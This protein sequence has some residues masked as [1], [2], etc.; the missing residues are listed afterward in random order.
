MQSVFIWYNV[1]MVNIAVCI[2][3]YNDCYSDNIVL[4]VLVSLF[5]LWCMSFL[6]VFL[7]LSFGFIELNGVWTV[8]SISLKNS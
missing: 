3:I 7:L 1:R 6:F 5:L 2:L 8:N 4:Y